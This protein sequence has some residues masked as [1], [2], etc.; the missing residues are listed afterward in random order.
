MRRRDAG[1]SLMNERPSLENIVEAYNV[2]DTFATDI[3]KVEK[4]GPCVRITFAVKQWVH[5]GRA[6]PSVTTLEYHVVDKLIVPSEMLVAMASILAQGDQTLEPVAQ[7][8]PSREL[9]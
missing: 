4:L 6:G 8:T 2:G 5:D 3:V 9:H 1:A 7:A